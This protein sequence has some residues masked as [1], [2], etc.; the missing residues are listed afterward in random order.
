MSETWGSTRFPPHPATSAPLCPSAKGSWL[1]H[2]TPVPGSP[3]GLV[4]TWAWP[5]AKRSPGPP[6]APASAG[7]ECA[8]RYPPVPRPPTVC[9]SGWGR[10]PLPVHGPLIHRYREA[11]ACFVRRYGRST[12]RRPSCSWLIPEVNQSASVPPFAAVPGSRPHRPGSVN[13][14][15]VDLSTT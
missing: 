15:P 3:A 7:R 5:P 9:K 12:P 10:E 4:T 6:H 13:G 14:L 8:L 11:G 2:A 1:E